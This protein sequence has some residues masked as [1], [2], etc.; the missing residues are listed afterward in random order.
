M[1]RSYQSVCILVPTIG[2]RRC[3]LTKALKSAVSVSSVFLQS[4]VVLDNTQDI[5]ESNFITALIEGLDDERLRIIRYPARLSMSQSWNSPLQSVTEE[6]ILYLH[7]DDELMPD[8]FEQVVWTS[9]NTSRSLIA[10]GYE[11]RPRKVSHRVGY[12]NTLN[13]V[14]LYCSII[15]NPPKFVSTFINRKMF[16]DSGGWSSDV[17]FALD[18]LGFLDLAVISEPSF[19]NTVIGYYTVDDNCASKQ[20]SRNDGYGD[21]TPDLIKEIFSRFRDPKIRS[22]TLGFLN[23]F[24]FSSISNKGR[25]T[26]QVKTYFNKFYCLIFRV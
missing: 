24:V 18:L 16:L 22:T 7:D 12:R 9:L 25:F 17:G 21:S 15:M 19:V 14:D 8:K 10:C 26:I 3:G 2:G 11:E 1:I 20:D 4:I 13:S 6:W 23:Q 5:D